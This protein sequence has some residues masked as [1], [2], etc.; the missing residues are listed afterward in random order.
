MG[1]G[2]LGHEATA[3]PVLD[4]GRA[5]RGTLRGVAA[6]AAPTSVVTGLLYYF[7]WARS[8]AQARLLGLESS[9]LDYSSQDYVLQSIVSMFSPVLTGLLV[10]IAG[11]LVHVL[12]LNRVG[13]PAFAARSDVGRARLRRVQILALSVFA[14]GLYALALGVAG[15]FVE[16]PSR[17]VSMSYPLCIT[18][19]VVLL[20]Y[21]VYLRLR[22][23][24]G[25]R[26]SG[27]APPEL[28]GLRLAVTSLVMVLLVVCLFWSV[29]NYAEIKGQDLALRVERALPFLPD[30][31]VYSGKRLYLEP[32]VTE[33][34]LTG[35]DGA[36]RFR[37]D[38]LKLLFRAGKRY[39][40]RPDDPA[41]S[42]VN[43]ILAEGDDLRFEFAEHR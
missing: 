32:P 10:S 41:G 23:R 13:D 16:R 40:L 17:L 11:L 43:I 4:P 37:Y 3:A 8:N 5:L 31:T 36:Y 38:N 14:A 22:F 1:T 15:A 18:A 19:S 39:F 2:G 29:S 42:R 24:N 28:G 6:V 12:V 21:A 7:G 35:E 33:T 34:A 26:P 9:L 20:S 30:A 27:P 25:R